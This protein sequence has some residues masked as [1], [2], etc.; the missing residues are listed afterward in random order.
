[1]KFHRHHSLA[2]VAATSLVALPTAAFADGVT[3]AS[4]TQSV[5]PGATI[6]VTKTVATPTIPPKP[7]VVLLVDSTYS[8]NPAIGNVQ[9]NLSTII[10]TVQTA[11]PDAQF[12]VA[13]Y[14]DMG[15]SQPFTVDS[16][17]T[18]SAATAIAAANSITASGGGDIPED[19][20]NA[21]YQVGSGAIGFRPDS[22]R[23][24]VWFGDAM[25]HDP[26]NGKTI[27]DAITALNG[28]SAKVLAINVDTGFASTALDASGQATQIATA[29]GGAYLGTVGATEV[30]S[31]ILEGLTNLDA[32]VTA[33]P[34]CDPGLSVSLS[35]ASQTVPSGTSA[36]F[37]EAITVAAGA[38]QGATLHCSTNFL[39]N[40]LDAGPA[41]V[42]SVA[43]TV[44]DVTA[45]T[46]SCGPGVNPAGITPPG[47]QNAGFYRL[48]AADNL[49]G[50]MVTV[51]DTK[52]SA[53]FGPYAPDTT[54]KLTQAL[55]A[56]PSAV[57]GE[58]AVNWKIM[59]KG[60]AL[61]TATDA[62]GNTA[63]ATCKVPPKS[64]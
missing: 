52:S 63:T 44:N 16:N 64:K 17:L 51:S 39:V 61:L 37:D 25:G 20:I 32:T 45:P 54:I 60:D 27:N 38:T 53:S 58:G 15:D 5:N 4:V 10:T 42:Q 11:Q 29:T 34:T 22:T 33:V 26:S 50:V 55:G 7:D 46:V 41:F 36:T 12:A 2:L 6:H 28:V 3:P 35:P 19:Q 40:G 1:M 13:D 56:A 48:V 62:A 18:A 57:P 31:K 59:L 43:I 21:L 47:Y 9:A 49:P 30:S 14:K 23:L 8:M 24:V